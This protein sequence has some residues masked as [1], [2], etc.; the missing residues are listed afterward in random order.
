MK[1]K[2]NAS[3]EAV[4]LL[5]QSRHSKRNERTYAV[6]LPEKFEQTEKVYSSK[7]CPICHKMVHEKGLRIHQLTAHGIPLSTSKQKLSRTKTLPSRT[8]QPSENATKTTKKQSTT[9]QSKQ[10]SLEIL[11]EIRARKRRGEAK[12]KKRRFK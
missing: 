12:S 6:S 3:Y 10:Q 9:V 2:A 5:P 8:R 11:E 1:R 7:K 4:P